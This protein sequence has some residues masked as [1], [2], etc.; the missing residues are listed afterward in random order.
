MISSGVVITLWLLKYTEAMADRQLYPIRSNSL[1]IE[2]AAEKKEERE[3]NEEKAR[4]LRR[5]RRCM[6]VK[7]RE[8]GGVGEGGEKEGGRGGGGGLTFEFKGDVLRGWCSFLDTWCG[9]QLPYRLKFSTRQPCHEEQ[10][11]TWLGDLLNHA[12]V[13]VDIYWCFILNFETIVL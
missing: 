3:K 5:P 10:L 9:Y 7:E 12:I 2:W 13:I 6:E 4:E 1:T 11:S 8:W